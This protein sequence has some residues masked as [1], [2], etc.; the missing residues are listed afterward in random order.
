VLSSSNPNLFLVQP[1]LD[2]SGNLSFVTA[3]DQNGSSVL[4]VRL[5][6]NGLGSPSPNTNISPNATFTIT[7][8]S[9]NDAPQFNIPTA[10]ASDEDQG[11][12]TVPRFAT[13]ILPGPATAFDELRQDLTFDVVALDP[14]VFEIQPEISVDGTLTYK[15][16]LDLNSNAGK[17]ARVVVTLR[18]NG[19][20][21]PLPDTNVSIPRTFTI[22]INPINDPPVPTS[23]ST[24]VNE[25]VRTTIQ[26]ADVL[27]GSVPGPADEIGEGQTVR[28][29]NIESTTGIG[30]LVIPVVSGDRIVR[31]DYIPPLNFV[32][33]DTIRY[34]ITDNGTYTPGQRSATGTMTININPINDPPVFTSGGNVTVLEDS[35]PYSQPWASNI[36]AGPPSAID[37]ISGPNAQTV[38]FEVTTNNQAM[39][40]V[41]PSISPSGQLTFTLAKDANG[42][43]A[44]VVTAVDNGPFTPAPNNNRSQASTFTITVQSVNDEPDFNT[45]PSVS[46]DEDS[47]P[48]VGQVLSN[49]VPAIGNNAVPPTALDET[50]QLLTMTTTNDRPSLFAVQPTVDSSG[51]LRFTPAANAFGSAVV[52]VFATDNGPGSAPNVNV[53][54]TKSFT[55]TVRPTNDA[56]FA[57]DDRYSTSETTILNVSAPGLLSNDSD[58]DPTDTVLTVKSF[59]ST[60]ARGALVS[61]GTN[62]S[63]SYNPTVSA[64]LKALVD[65]Q[66]L[67]DTFTYTIQD[68]SATESNVATVTVT[69]SGFN[70][71]PVTANDDY[72]I[73][74]GTTQSLSVLDNDFDVDTPIDVRSI[75]IGRLPANGVATPTSD[76]KVRYVPSPGF[77]GQDSFTYRVRDSLGKAS[78]EATV[79]IRVNTS[80]VAVSDT[81]TARQGVTTTLNVLSNDTDPDGTINPATVSIVSNPNGASLVVQP[82]GQILFTPIE[83][84]LGTSRFQYTVQDNEG[85]QS[86]AAEVVVQV[87]SSLFQNPNNR[88][89]VNADGFVSPIDVLVII[90]LLNTMG[91]SVPVDGLPGPPDYVD[92]NGNNTVEPLDALEVIN[93]I[94]SGG[95]DGGGEGEGSSDSI[96]S[97]ELGPWNWTYDLGMNTGSSASL[98]SQSRLVS[99]DEDPRSMTV[100]AHAAQPWSSTARLASN[101]S[102]AE[103][104]ANLAEDEDDAIDAA[105]AGASNAEDRNAVDQAM[106][107][108]FDD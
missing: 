101:L 57:A 42:Q 52:Q 11:L 84:F 14:S 102:L 45:V 73:P 3:A 55:I 97:N 1:T 27:A 20:T 40:S 103:Y 75:E 58:V 48:F 85:I 44:V 86:N 28:M 34:V 64:T 2:A 72:V 106:A 6:D 31:F 81:F 46:V 66:T 50:T 23:Y 17:D 88:Y 49:I 18:D 10:F 47:G 37:E 79:T 51:V 78:L 5:E 76:G 4:V 59:Q 54:A 107:D 25:D 29:T 22:T 77:R 15:T 96:V 16:A 13:N 21:G 43:V 24:S 91:P 69:V 95:T 56:P 35:A 68:A 33:Q 36:A 39:F 99:I 32:G 41:L 74:F 108:W 83:G 80:P 105:L 7:V 70:D 61:V 90:N 38:D 8:R 67:S 98:N 94:N 63:L 62:G 100:F 82:N 12:M 92:V 9:V 53:S 19:T 89:D 104:L 26:A 93:F 60:S 71:A 87:V 30:G 65:G